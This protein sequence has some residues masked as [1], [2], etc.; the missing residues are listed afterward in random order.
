MKNFTSSV[1]ILFI[2]MSSV[3]YGQEKSVYQSLS[4]NA[5]LIKNSNA[6]VRYEKMEVD[7]KSIRDMEMKQ[8]RVITVL[9][10]EGL[11][12]L[13]PYVHYNNGIKVKDIQMLI[14]DR[15]GEEVNKFKKKDFKDVSAVSGGTLYSDS[16]VL[17]LDYT[18]VS[19][20]FTVEFSYEIA[21]DNSAILPSWSF[22]SGYNLSTEESHYIVHYDPNETS[23]RIKESRLEGYDIH[24]E[25][26]EGYLAY[27]GKN[28]EAI[29]KEDLAPAF[30]KIVPRVEVVPKRFFY[31]GYEGDVS[32][33]NE[34]G[35]WMYT[36]ILS[37]RQE[38]P[39]ATIATV[40]ALVKGVD[41]DYEKAKIIYKYVQ[42]N[43]RYISVQVGIGGMQPIAAIDVDKVKYGDCKGLSNYTMALL[44]AVGVESYYTHV[45]AGQ[46][47]DSFHA[48]FPSLA[49]GNHII[50][51]IPYK[52]E[53]LW[54]DCTSQSLPFNFVGDFTDNR[55]VCVIKPDGGEI[56]TTPSYLDENNY[57]LT[58]ANYVI[59]D[60]GSIS[61]EIDM[62]SNGIAYDNAYYVEDSD[63]EYVN[64]YYKE[65]YWKYMNG[66]QIDSYS[67]K[68]DKDKIEFKEHLKVE[69]RNYANKSGEQLLIM[70]NA[71]DRYRSI[72]DRYR[73][74][75]LPFQVERGFKEEDEFIITLPEKYTM[76]TL[77]G[78][79]SIANKFGEYHLTMEMNEDG[80]LIMKRSLLIR[81]G[82]YE[83]DDYDDFR[84]FCKKVAQY[85]VSKIVLKQTDKT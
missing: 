63:D 35:K 16:R 72:P 83:K 18:P 30:S 27:S 15:T 12:D 57:K 67:F 2:A 75:K 78:A 3:L 49:Q 64:R 74:R 79:V 45:E 43:T 1:M 71:F 69:V 8:V 6:L 77:P 42:E 55:R 11:D 10:E 21:T 53:M 66:L 47:I 29:K 70:P 26:S 4:M 80:K 48:E 44:R 25:E 58:K 13:K 37:G 23:L 20:P 52:D 51:A 38:L 65:Y 84:D 73:S 34:F 54:V 9:N 85:D 17:Y 59:Q 31:E 19:Y 46:S 14:F 36:R 41:D 60:D 32:D 50:L 81:H 33:W 7:M 76:P 24:K 22:L 28:L 62:T 56:M 68:N 5:E 40:T 82:E 61:G 39:P